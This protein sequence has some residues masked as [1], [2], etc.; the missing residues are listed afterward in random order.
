[1]GARSRATLPWC[2]LGAVSIPSV[3]LGFLATGPLHGYELKK[4]YDE[5]FPHSR[6]LAY[7]QVYTTLQRL[8]R[9]GLIEVLDTVA[10]GAAERT[11]YRITEAGAKKLQ[12]WLAEPV[13]PAP[14]V[15]NEIFAKVVLALLAGDEDHEHS[16]C[17]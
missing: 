14:F 7:G 6:P 11:R 5:R 9:D 13:P 1:L 15:S 8:L 12:G 3:L 16:W 2:T 10:D 17:I 4:R